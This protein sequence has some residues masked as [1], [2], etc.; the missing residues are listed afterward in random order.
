MVANYVEL[1]RQRYQGQIDDKADKYI[2]YATDGAVRMQG[3]I[4]DL[5]TYSRVGRREGAIGPVSLGRVVQRAAENLTAAIGLS[6][7]RIDSGPLPIVSG[8]EAQLVQLFQN[9]IDNAIKFR[10]KDLPKI[11]IDAETRGH[12]DAARDMT[13]VSDIWDR[14]PSPTKTPSHQESPDDSTAETQSQQGSEHSI[15]RSLD[16]SIP[17]E[18]VE[19]AKSVDVRSGFVTIRV[20]DNGIGID[21]KHADRIFRLFQRLHT[22][23]EYPGTG[24]GLAVCKKIVERHGG[25]I[26][27]ESEPGKGSAFVFTLPVY[28]Q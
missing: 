1:L 2:R 27:V 3:L 14:V 8:D 26:R 25:T 11:R 19:S 5:L 9:L 10:G 20:T 23:E 24:I 21:P 6:D 7:A 13:Q 4:H 15:S 22:H 12:G 18:S 28:V 16:P 17:S